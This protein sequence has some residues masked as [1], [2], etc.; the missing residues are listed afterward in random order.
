MKLHLNTDAGQLLFTGYGEDHVLING[1]RHDASL[2][3]TARGIEIAPWAGLGFDALTAAHFEWIA[4]REL[5]ILL[6]GTGTRLRFPHPSL[7]RAL[8]DARIGLEV[9]DIGALCRTYN[10]L[11]TEGRSVGAAVLIEPAAG[12]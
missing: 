1:H 3:L 8:I 4:Q 2:L 11:V 12:D 6:L 9:M 7:T 10:I 5:D